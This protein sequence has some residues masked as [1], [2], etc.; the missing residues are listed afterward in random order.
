MK[1]YVVLV[2]TVIFMFCM[3][4]VFV[5]TEASD[6]YTVADALSVLRAVV[7]DDSSHDV[8][9]DGKTNFFDVLL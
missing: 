6:N 4:N 8:N 7:N 3:L 9:F 2:L 1:K 5:S